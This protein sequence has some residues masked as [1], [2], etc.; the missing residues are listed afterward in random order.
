[1][2]VGNNITNVWTVV[3][4]PRPKLKLVH[5]IF[6]ENNQ[7]GKNYG[8]FAFMTPTSF[9]IDMLKKKSSYKLAQQKLMG[10]ALFTHIVK[11]R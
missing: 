7:E 8:N 11:L 6:F 10:N 1:M 4:Q 3:E 2:D 5:N 9:N